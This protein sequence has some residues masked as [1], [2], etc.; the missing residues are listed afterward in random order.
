M[1]GNRSCRRPFLVGAAASLLFASLARSHTESS[2]QFCTLRV[3]AN[4]HSNLLYCK[5]FPSTRFRV[6]AVWQTGPFSQHRSTLVDCS[7]PTHIL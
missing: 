4:Q 3:T 6:S 7:L 2:F 5:Q 1:T